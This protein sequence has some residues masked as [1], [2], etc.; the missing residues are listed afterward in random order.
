MNKNALNHTHSRAVVTPVRTP[1]QGVADRQLAEQPGRRR[2]RYPGPA[3]NLAESQPRV[4]DVEGGQHG[5][6]TG[7]HRPPGIPTTTGHHS[8]R[9]TNCFLFVAHICS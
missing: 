1:Y 6:Y 3:G 5:E 8:P 2:H 9:Y 4:L 7:R